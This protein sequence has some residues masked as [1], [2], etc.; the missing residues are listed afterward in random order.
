MR[1]RNF[2]GRLAAY[3][4]LVLA[5]W[6]ASAS[7][8]GVLPGPA[9]LSAQEP[10]PAA[11]AESAPPSPSPPASRPVAGQLVLASA[12]S[13][14]ESHGWISARTRH[15]SDLYNQRLR[16]EGVYQQ[17]PSLRMRYEMRTV[18]GKNAPATLLQICDG[19]TFWSV[20][21]V[22][23]A[24]SLRKIDGREVFQAL[25]ETKGAPP[26]NTEGARFLG[27]GGLPQLLRSIA[28]DFELEP[29]DAA[30]PESQP[31]RILLVGTWRRDAMVRLF[32]QIL[33]KFGP[34]QPVDW[35]K[36][37][38]DFP[39]QVELLLGSED[40]FPYQLRYLR[41][42][43]P[44]ARAAGLKV[45]P[46]LTLEFFDVEFGKPLP[47]TVFHY[48][49]APSLVVADGTREYIAKLGLK[50]PD[51]AKRDK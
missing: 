37:P 28:S 49:P 33:A 9:N 17:G 43:R 18:L 25:R 42:A 5:A 50:I 20:T 34:E 41:L 38:A 27:L 45:E 22:L 30:G 21:D 19:T 48:E 6:L 8:I 32:P 24:V 47:D 4:T 10:Q 35:N 13:A 23:G 3:S 26:P 51:G 44:A 29:F 31:S 39:Q 16:G 7:P 11:P 15:E 12:V 36:L 2:S 1:M 40:L 46:L 14:I